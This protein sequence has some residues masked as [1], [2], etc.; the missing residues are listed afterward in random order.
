MTIEESLMRYL[1]SKTAITDLV[2]NKI[3]F[4]RAPVNTTAPYLIMQKI[5][6]PREQAFISNPGLVI[7]RIQLTAVDYDYPGVKSIISALNTTS[8]LRDFT[9]IMGT[10]GAQVDYTEFANEVDI[11]IDPSLNL[12]GVAAD[13]IISYHE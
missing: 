11:E 9:G 7:S 10:S 5:S 1:K 2:G 12:Y 8:V 3:Y 13:W 6:A 4:L